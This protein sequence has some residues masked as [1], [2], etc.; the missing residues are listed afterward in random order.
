MKR[1]F[2]YILVLAVV[3]VIPVNRVDI[4]K[5]RPVQAVVVYR[6]EANVVI[7]TDTGDRGEGESAE[8]ALKNLKATT[9]AVIYLDTADFIIVAENAQNDA[10]QLR[11]HF[12][13]AAEVYGFFGKAEAEAAAKYLS[14]HGGGLQ[15][16]VWKPGAKIPVLDFRNERIILTEKIEINA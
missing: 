11:E 5:L 4:G 9:P 8:E 7:E 14:I 6:D 12:R 1:C 10:Q 16:R 15:L 13:R 3:L 2:I